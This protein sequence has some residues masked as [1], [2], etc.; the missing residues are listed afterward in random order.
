MNFTAEDLA[1]LEAM[2]PTVIAILYRQAGAETASTKV[3]VQA[4][5]TAKAMVSGSREIAGRNVPATGAELSELR[6]LLNARRM[7]LVGGN[8][9]LAH[10][11]LT[12]Q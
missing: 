5:R 11:T 8:R 1:D 2:R 3:R 7:E 9:H 4:L 12:M 6:M 10:V